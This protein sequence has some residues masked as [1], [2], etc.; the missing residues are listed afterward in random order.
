MHC[1]VRSRV[2]VSITLSWSYSCLVTMTVIQRSRCLITAQVKI[3]VCIS[4]DIDVKNV[5][6]VFYSG[7]VFSAFLFCQRFLF[8]KAFIENTI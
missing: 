2:C 3:V 6:Y 7:H 5:F 1:L 8:L 4:S